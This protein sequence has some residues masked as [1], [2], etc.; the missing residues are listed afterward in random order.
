MAREKK[1]TLPDEQPGAPEW[2]VTFSDCMTLLLTFFVLL[3]SFSSFDN[4]IFRSLKVVYSTALT[5]ITPLRQSDRNAL[6]TL[7]PI[8]I[9]AELDKGS[10]KP[11]LSQELQ[12]GLLKE[13]KMMDLTTGVAFL[14]S[15]KRIFWAKGSALSQEGRR[16]MD[17]MASYLRESPCR[18]VISENGPG[19][20]NTGEYFGLPRA[21]TVLEYL[22][23]EQNLDKDR[24]SISAEGVLGK[25]SLGNSRPDQRSSEA[26]RTVEIVLLQRSIYN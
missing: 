8:K 20:D 10:E 9:I 2:M 7:H 19:K 26:E 18:I 15:S 1:Q 6:S 3:L 4:R 25:K 24:L 17:L 23:N 5:S 12:D 11:T 13:T 21:W 14:I 16:L 22:T